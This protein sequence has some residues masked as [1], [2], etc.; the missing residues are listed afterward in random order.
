MRLEK[1]FAFDVPVQSLITVLTSR[2]YYQVRYRLSAEQ[3]DFTLWE[4]RSDGLHVHVSKDVPIRVENLPLILRKFVAPTMTLK[5]EFFWQG[6]EP[7]VRHD[8][9]KS[10]CRMTLGKAPVEIRG[11]MQLAADGKKTS[12]QQWVLDLS[13]SIPVLGSKL[14]ERAGPK[15]LELLD[16]E[17]EAIQAFLTHA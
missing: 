4:Q 16:E 14:L 8:G 15:L 13:C 5:T 2:D 10:Q 3:Q 1:T 12:R 6:F 9:L 7:G 17:R 11:I